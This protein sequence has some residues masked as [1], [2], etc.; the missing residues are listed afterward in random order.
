MKNALR[1]LIALVVATTVI[2]GAFAGNVAAAGDQSD[3]GDQSNY[4]SDN[5]LVDAQVNAGNPTL[6]TSVSAANFGNDNDAIAV[7]DS[8]QNAGDQYTQINFD[9]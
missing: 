7:A 2:G 5:D 4:I 6:A 3:S 8:D 1:I 9:D